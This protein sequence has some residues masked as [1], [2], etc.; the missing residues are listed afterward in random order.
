MLGRSE[1]SRLLHRIKM[2]TPDSMP[3][4]VEVFYGLFAGLSFLSGLA[5]TVLFILYRELR[6]GP[7]SLI[8]GQS[9]AQM[10]LDFHWFTYFVHFHDQSCKAL[11][12]IAFFAYSLAFAY[13]VLVCW[14]VSKHFYDHYIPVMYS[15][16][17]HAL[18]IGAAGIATAIA[19]IIHEFGTS[20][21]GTCFT[22]P[23]S[24]AE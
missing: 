4:A 10:I 7:G 15:V 8:L 12:G 5:I 19:G 13:A 18:C 16:A 11:G 2:N 3:V 20:V 21:M 14:V 17:Y 23:R 9:I 22:K 6:K 1:A 24:Y